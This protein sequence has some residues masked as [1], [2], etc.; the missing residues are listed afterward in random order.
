MEPETTTARGIDRLREWFELVARDPNPHEQTLPAPLPDPVVDG[1]FDSYGRFF[2]KLKMTGWLE[3]VPTAPVEDGNQ[4]MLDA[5]EDDKSEALRVEVA[6]QLEMEKRAFGQAYNLFTAGLNLRSYYCGKKPHQYD[7]SKAALQ[8]Q[9]LLLQNYTLWDTQLDTAGQLIHL[10]KLWGGAIL[11]DHMGAGK[12][13]TI[14]AL[15]AHEADH[16]TDVDM[17]FQDPIGHYSEYQK[18]L[19]RPRNNSRLRTLIVVPHH[20]T[21]TVWMSTVRKAF[22]I[23]EGRESEKYCAMRARV[24]TNAS[25]RSDPNIALQLQ[26]SE[27]IITDY[28]TVRSEFS[29]WKAWC[30]DWELLRRGKR[31]KR[32]GKEGETVRI[33]TERI[34]LPILAGEY[35]RCVLDEAHRIRNGVAATT[36]AAAVHAIRATYRIAVTGT[37][38]N[39]DYTDVR[40]I[41]E[42]LRI[43][44]WDNRVFFRSTFMKKLRGARDVKKLDE[45]R[46]AI[47]SLT[48][49]AVM[50][51][52]VQGDEYCKP[53]CPPMPI[54]PKIDCDSKTVTLD[55]TGE[56]KEAQMLTSTSGTRSTGKCIRMRVPMF[57]QSNSSRP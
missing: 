23:V 48:L 56:E 21:T 13:L 32:G 35:H 6:H 10:E 41:L 18:T 37:P 53:N 3:P 30:D 28:E 1:I 38:F 39:N 29:R 33:S 20:L 49:L 5:R 17:S 57:R 14:L 19:G 31:Y 11:G 36:T 4:P 2:S 40:G 16:V 34:C 12:T 43:P 9:P 44:P 15:I 8:R 52:H 46:N 50:V 22:P 55:P 42:F 24:Y 47:L 51:R 7:R 26:D 45:V 25:H 27:I 54:F